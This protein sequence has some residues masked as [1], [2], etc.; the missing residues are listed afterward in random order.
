MPH[1][2]KEFAGHS[3]LLYAPGSGAGRF[4]EWLKSWVPAEQVVGMLPDIPSMIVA[5][6]SGLGIGPLPAAMAAD[7]PE[8]IQCFEA[9]PEG[10]AP[11]WLVT[12]PEAHKRREVRAFADFLAPRY[13]DRIGSR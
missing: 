9:P 12:I 6:R 2:P 8:L 10:I 3:F 7:V 11:T 13:T 4:N 1:G 5:V